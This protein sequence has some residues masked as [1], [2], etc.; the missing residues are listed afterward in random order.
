M[1]CSGLKVRN[2][3]NPS[4]TRLTLRSGSATFSHKGE[5]ERRDISVS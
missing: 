3:Q 5:K 4:G 1:R 2:V